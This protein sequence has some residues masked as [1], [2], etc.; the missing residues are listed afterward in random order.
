MPWIPRQVDVFFSVVCLSRHV[1]LDQWRLPQRISAWADQRKSGL[2]D[3]T[4]R[5]HLIESEVIYLV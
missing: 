5:I 1:A 2:V 4:E 3:I